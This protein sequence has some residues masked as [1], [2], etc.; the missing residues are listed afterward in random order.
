MMKNEKKTMHSAVSSR[1]LKRGKGF[2][3]HAFSA[4]MSTFVMMVSL[5][6]LFWMIISIFK[7]KRQVS[8][9]IFWP[10]TLNLDAFTQ[11]ADTNFFDSLMVTFIGALISVTLCIIINLLAAYAFA[12]L[13]F[14]GKKILWVLV[15]L[16]MFVPG[17]T[18]LVPLFLVCSKLGILDTMTVLI[19]PGV[20]QASHIFFMRQ[21]FLNLPMS[22]EEAAK[23][24]GA[25]TIQIFTHLF[26]PLSL[27]PT[28]IVAISAF[29]G[30]WNAYLWPVLVVERQSLQQIMQVIYSFKP[31]HDPNWP[32][33]MLASTIATMIPLMIYL[34]FNKQIVES[35]KISGIK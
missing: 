33:I 32:L 15:L 4:I 25:S 12:R 11:L 26:V 17:M 21:F 10:T 31:S 29:M 9:G 27:G 1:R 6:P 7:T 23:I 35:L 19:I 14:H 20:A 28:I 18:I 2:A 30:Y 13:D 3:A 8:A 5:F 22:L 24:D 34:I 16:P